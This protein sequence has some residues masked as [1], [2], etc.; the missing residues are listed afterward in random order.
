QLLL[1]RHFQAHGFLLA[2]NPAN[3]FFYLLTGAHGLHLAGGLYAC[4]RT[5]GLMS[6]QSN[7]ARVRRNVGLCA[8]Y[9]HFFF[10]VWLLL[11]ALLVAT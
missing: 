2:S 11:V 9:W 8:I 6:S 5:I 1:W 7:E 10:L 4:G 3:A